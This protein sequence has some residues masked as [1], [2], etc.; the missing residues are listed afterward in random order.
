MYKRSV[1][2]DQI[3]KSIRRSIFAYERYRILR[4]KRNKFYADAVIRGQKRTRYVMF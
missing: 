2:V 3:Q 1:Y 4:T